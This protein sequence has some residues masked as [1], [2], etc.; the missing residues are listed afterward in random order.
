[1]QQL[2]KKYLTALAALA[3]AVLLSNDNF[4][5]AVLIKHAGR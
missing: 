4:S 3:D 2:S 5:T 1:M